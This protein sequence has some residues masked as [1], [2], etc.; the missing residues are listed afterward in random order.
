MVKNGWRALLAATT[1]LALS[2]SLSSA[3]LA[4]GF[5]PHG[6]A[7]GGH[8]NPEGPLGLLLLPPEFVLGVVAFF[9][10]LYAVRRRRG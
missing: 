8:P 6:D 9:S 2:L 7:A 10:L 3:A 1:A 5:A 4:H